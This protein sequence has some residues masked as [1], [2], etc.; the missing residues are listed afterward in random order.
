[1]TQSFNQALYACVAIVIFLVIFYVIIPYIFKDVAAHR[2]KKSTRTFSDKQSILLLKGVCGFGNANKLNTSNKF[3]SNYI[4]LPMAI[5]RDGGIEFSY[6]FWTKLGE[7][8]HDNTIFTKGTNPND[9]GLTEEFSKVYNDKGELTIDDKRL[10]QSPMVKMSKENVTVSFN[11]AKRIKNT[12]KFELDKNRILESTEDNPRWFLFTF[13][14][15]EGNFTTDYG[16]KTKGVILEIFL[17]E[18]HIKTHFVE[19]D[20]MKL[21]KG[22]LFIFPDSHSSAE[23]DSMAGNLIYHNY[24]LSHPDVKK[25]WHA[26]VDTVGCTVAQKTEEAKTS[27]QI[28][29]LGKSGAQFLI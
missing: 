11:T 7:L 10:L 4:D 13:T 8:K 2:K 27:T 6:S 9:G 23:R 20:S 12:V 17:N 29:D 21:N 16:L 28:N 14:F 24:A 5:N 22:D 3:K 15:R 18:Q 25:L 19:D 26:G 1:M